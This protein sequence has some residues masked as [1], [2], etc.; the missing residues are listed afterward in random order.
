MNV[1]NM[2]TSFKQVQLMNNS[3]VVLDIDET[4]LK[5]E[6]IDTK[7][8]KN[9]FDHYYKIH[10]HNDKSHDY[11]LNEWIDYITSV[12]PLHTDK[13]GF[14]DLEKRLTDNNCRLV[15]VTARNKGL[16]QITHKHFIHLQIHNN[17]IYFTDGTNK[18]HM[19][20]QI[21]QKH[22]TDYDKII[23]VDDLERNL[24]DVR[25]HFNDNVICYKF[26]SAV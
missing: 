7:W 4:L 9:R 22:M 5:Y 13:E 14:L 23:F 6:S 11:V 18:A 1:H 17:E 16:E 19:I 26:I 12:D 15:F 24:N 25:T 21:I 20:E 3:L 10:T 8:W 2:I